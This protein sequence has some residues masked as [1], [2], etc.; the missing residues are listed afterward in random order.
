[1]LRTVPDRGDIIR[2]LPQHLRD[3]LFPAP[4]PPEPLPRK[5]ELWEKY[6]D[7]SGNPTGTPL[8]DW[9]QPYTITDSGFKPAES[10]TDIMSGGGLM[11]P[12]DTGNRP[13]DLSGA[14][15]PNV[16]APTQ[17]P[18]AA[19]PQQVTAHTAS[20]W[21]A[22]ISD[23]FNN[24]NWT[25]QYKGINPRSG[26]PISVGNWYTP[27]GASAAPANTAPAATPV[28][29]VPAA[30]GGSAIN[31]D[32]LVQELAEKF[33][34]DEWRGRGPQTIYPVDPVDTQFDP[35]PLHVDQ[36][37][38]ITPE[39]KPPWWNQVGKFLG[40]TAKNLPDYIPNLATSRPI[41][42]TLPPETGATEALN[43]QHLPS[44]IQQLL[45][46]RRA[47]IGRKGPVDYR[48]LGLRRNDLSRLMRHGGVDPR[49]W[50]G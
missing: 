31:N 15:T 14:F 17:Q 4:P 48:E 49:D 35:T 23:F 12:V 36:G 9:P 8:P 6:W 40:T 3:K 38:D 44:H 10:I 30:A 2:S 16:Q 43:Y 39:E 11:H 1:M 25:R 5:K 13:V 32:P 26:E 27:G 19:A 21:S 47:G 34:N 42:S 37:Q 22:S 45:F 7:S 33:R 28:N 50:G 18:V 20:P 46:A 29:V 41:T 24:D